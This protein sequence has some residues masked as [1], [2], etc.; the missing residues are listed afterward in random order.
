MSKISGPHSSSANKRERKI[1]VFSTL[2][3][4]AAFGE[5]STGLIV[6]AMPTLGELFAK[7]PGVI[8]LTITCFAIMFAG[9]QLFFGPFSDLRGRR[10]A[11]TIGAFL[12]VLGSLLA[13]V[14]DSFWLIVLGR[15]IQGL[16][17]SSGYVIARAIIRDLYGAE[18]SAKAMAVLFAFM[19]A[20]FLIAPLIGGNLIDIANWRSGFF[21]A[22]CIA[23]IWLILN[24]FIMPETKMIKDHFNLSKVVLVYLDLFKH[25][26]F[27]AFMLTHSIAYAGL[28]CFV[29]G[30]P[31]VFIESLSITPANYGIIA[32]LIM[33]GFFIGSS[34]ARYAIPVLGMKTVIL[35]SLGLMIIAP[36][37]MVALVYREW[38]DMVLIIPLGFLYWFGAGFLAP[39]TAAGVMMSHPDAAG[40]A[41]AV[42][43]FSRMCLAGIVSL[44]QGLIYSGSLM[45][46]V[47]MQFLLGLLTLV[48]WGTLVRFT[49]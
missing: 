5:V 1:L 2:I 44:L 49:K 42:L 31:Y 4:C 15:A 28:Y 17:A 18:E 12:T 37:I 14:A 45:T 22:T 35:I 32:A 9:G 46:V 26:G 39:N 25:F 7:S 36:G 10:T 23:F 3:I 13:T 41:A 27:L 30:G 21:L 20:S 43:G 16:G 47:G 29:S 19:S 11:L 34:A 38:L 48:I 6:P 40:A 24:L 8:Q 33:S